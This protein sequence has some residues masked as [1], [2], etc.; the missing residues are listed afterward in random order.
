MKY[1][2]TIIL[3]G[4][5]AAYAAAIY[6]SRYNMKALVIQEEFGGE[7][8]TAGPIENYPGSKRKILGSILSRGKQSL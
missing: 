6:A 3:G 1:Y 2:D 4:G 7:T 8:A 5:A